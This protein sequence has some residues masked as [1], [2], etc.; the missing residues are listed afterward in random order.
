[1][2]VVFLMDGVPL[3]EFIFTRMPGDSY[4]RRFG[5]L[6]VTVF[7]RTKRMFSLTSPLTDGVVGGHEGRFS[8]DPLPV[9]YAGDPCG[10]FWHGQGCPLF[11]A[12]SYTHLTLPTTRMV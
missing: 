8:R 11:D 6:A 9:F 2:K 12:V 10:Q 7:I 3:T 5:S 4:R 1:M